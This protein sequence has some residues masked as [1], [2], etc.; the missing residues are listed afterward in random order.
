[1]GM[2]TAL[3][4]SQGRAVSGLIGGD[5]HPMA[6]GTIKS[7]SPPPYPS[8]PFIQAAFGMQILREKPRK[9]YEEISH[10]QK[11]RTLLQFNPDVLAYDQLSTYMDGEVR[12]PNRELARLDIAHQLDR[13][14]TSGWN[15]NIKAGEEEAQKRYG[16]LM[17]RMDWRYPDGSP[18]ESPRGILAETFDGGPQEISFTFNTLGIPSVFGPGGL[19]LLVE[20]TDVRLGQ[21]YS[22]FLV[23]GVGVFRFQ[24]L[25]FSRWARAAFQ[26]HLQSLS[27]ERRTELGIDDPSTFAIREYL[28]R[29]ELTPKDDSSPLEDPVFREYLLHHHEGIDAW[30]EDYREAVEERYPARMAADEVALYANQFTG[31]FGNP[32]AANVYVSDSLDVIYTELFPR[33]EPAVDV[34]YKTMR[35]AGNF[36]KPVV[37][38]GTLANLPEEQLGGIDPES[39]NPNLLQFQA[40]EAYASGAR[41]QLPLT[42]RAAYS[43]ADS[44]TNWVKPDGTVPAQLRSF[45]DFLW[46]H[47]RFLTGLQPAGDV[48]VVWSLPTRLWRHEPGWGIGQGESPRID[49]FLGTSALLREAGFAYEVLTFGHPRL[50]DDRGQLDR[51]AEYNTVVLPS[52]ESITDGQLD[53]LATYLDNDGSIVISGPLPERDGFY[54]PRS[55]VTSVLDHENVTVLEGDPGQRK[56]AEGVTDGSL[57]EALK[58]HGI[59]PYRMTDDPSIAVHSHRQSDPD[60]KVIQLLNYEYDASTDTFKSKTDLTIQVP[61]TTLE[62]PVVRFYSPDAQV[63]LDT[64]LEGETILV[65]VPELVEWGMLVLADSPESF[66]EGDPEKARSRIQEAERFLADARDA[67]QDGVDE[68]VIGEERLRAA[69]TA[70]Q[71]RAF[72]Q[73]SEAAEEALSAIA[74]LVP[75]PTATASQT[76]ETPRDGTMTGE[77]VPETSTTAGETTEQDPTRTSS[78]GQPGFGIISAM[79]GLVSAVSY[80]IWRD[81]LEEN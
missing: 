80:W 55:D 43:E 2:A 72:A 39:P 73:A 19:D 65:V 23:D 14:A 36:S 20:A 27:V 81:G 15:V 61:T 68:F 78:P 1:M 34:N 21:G 45:A 35:S 13:P 26:S 42:A 37:G 67:G 31:H 28:H 51:L 3:G 24:G 63:E 79:A 6:I 71:F 46:A 33:V 11:L 75:T 49:S 38:K 69:R 52:V 7:T 44:I 12:T 25:D 48:A 77:T 58:T 22:G 57:V 74:P 59:R 70:L 56:E 18:L 64:Q 53:A 8:D 62:D 76:E 30:F 17:E 66:V 50:W 16:P 5:R 60:R 9:G 32:Q 41:F 10:Q 29:N 47:E 40:A 54:E 4:L